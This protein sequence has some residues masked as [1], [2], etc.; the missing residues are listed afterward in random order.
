M[1][2]DE[3]ALLEQLKSDFE[4]GNLKPCALTL[5]KLA[6]QYNV[7]IMIHGKSST[8]KFKHVLFNTNFIKNPMGGKYKLKD[9]NNTLEVLGTAYKY[10]SMANS[11]PIP[12]E[13]APAAAFKFDPSIL[14][15]LKDMITY[16]ECLYLMNGN[17]SARLD[18]SPIFQLP[19]NTQVIAI[20]I[21]MMDQFRVL[22]K[23]YKQMVGKSGVTGMEM[24]ISNQP[25]AF[26]EDLKGAPADN[27]ELMLEGAN[28]LILYLYFKNRKTFPDRID[29][30]QLVVTGTLPY[31][32][33]EFMRYILAAYQRHSLLSLEEGIRYGH[34][35]FEARGKTEKGTTVYQYGFED[36]ERA[37]ARY[38]A[39]FRRDYDHISLSLIDHRNRESAFIAQEYQPRLARELLDLQ[40]KRY[41]LIQLTD[42]HPDKALFMKASCDATIKENQVDEQTKQY[43]LG[44]KTNG[45]LISDLVKACHY[46]C[47]IADIVYR[48]SF[49]NIREDEPDTYLGELAIADI[50]YLAEELSRLYGYDAKYAEKLIDC[51]VFHEKDN[52]GEDIFSQP[53]VKISKSQVIICYPLL[54]QINLDRVIERLLS[55]FNVDVS[56]VGHV[57]EKDFKRALADGYFDVFRNIHNVP[58]PYFRVNE[59][60]V[61]Y[62]AFDGKDIEFDVVSTL[63]DYLILTELKAVMTSYELSE[64]DSKKKHVKKAIEQLLR[65][66]DSV[67][68]DWEKFKASV[69]IDLPDA[70]YDDDHIILVACTDA[71]DF[72]PLKAGDVYITDNSAYLKYF[73]NPFVDLLRIDKESGGKV[74]KVKNIWR[75]GRPDAQEFIEYLQRP[76]TIIN[77]DRCMEKRYSP[78]NPFDSQDY[79]ILRA[80]YR[81]VK[82]PVHIA[83]EDSEKKTYPND[84]CPCG[85]GKK[86]KKCCMR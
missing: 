21:F 65:R 47:T 43:Y 45:I 51:F 2:S 53:L 40:E 80:D 11:G 82:D 38:Y 33:A 56:P 75:K 63:G 31:D 42:F 41:H 72:T 84:P 54:D 76:E 74:C 34:Y 58:I 10:I 73:C 49:S 85:S 55:R 71:Y 50:T 17:N 28:Q 25:V 39:L 32:N 20:M 83:K 81:L 67:K 15:D 59:G 70:P 66:R 7:D 60:E 19:F 23:N 35:S 1:A 29:P 3:T 48:A 61:K 30:E 13:D 62:I 46:L 77:Y 79:G 64:L 5:V 6:I 14:S 86:Y 16:T 27:L 36:E 44:C 57:F 12:Q 4:A 69:S 37:K 22:D 24:S 8:H 26:Y 78:I 52:K 9:Y 68:K 18:H